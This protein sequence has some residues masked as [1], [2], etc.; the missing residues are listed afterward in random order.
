MK[1]VFFTLLI[2]LTVSF[3]KADSVFIEGFE[4]GNHDGEVPIGWTCSDNSW[5]AG[6]LEKDHN[7]IPNSGNWYAYTNANDSWMF[8][9]FFMANDLKYRYHFW[10]IAD[11][12]Y[13]VEIWAGSGP[14]QSQMTTML[15]TRT[16]NNTEYQQFAE[17]I[18]SLTADYQYFGIHAVAH[19]GSY[20]LTIDDFL[21]DMVVRYEITANPATLYTT[22]LPGSQVE[23]ACTVTNL[24]YEPANVIIS[25]R[26]D[27]FSDIHVYKDGAECTSFHAE[28]DESVDITGVAT[29]T[30]DIEPEAYGWAD[31]TF[32]LD[33]D[34]ASTMF[35][36]WAKAEYDLIE[37]N[38]VNT[39]NIYPN[40]SSGKVNI[41]GNGKISIFNCLGQEVFTK[42]I[43]DKET[44]ILESGLYFVKKED[45]SAAKLIVR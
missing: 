7:R 31:I 29:F 39:M 34:C 3:A 8:M 42:K 25:R 19:E 41:E 6:Y 12:E 18:E 17:Y 10:A 35:T 40:P 43:I 36:L 21:I 26:S 37:E 24:G 32:T 27:Y 5:L 4:Y 13:D 14:S 23:F 2:L 11:G 33:C 28:P 9:E 1:R 30:S 44:V 16:I 15:F 20:H 45:G 38:D 22:A